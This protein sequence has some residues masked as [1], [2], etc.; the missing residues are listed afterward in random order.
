MKPST[1]VPKA[2]TTQQP[3]TQ[4]PQSFKPIKT[5]MS[6]VKA[7]TIAYKAVT[8]PQNRS[9]SAPYN[10]PTSKPV[11][12][13]QNNESND[14]VQVTR[15]I[16]GKK[17]TMKNTTDKS[18]DRVKITS[19]EKKTNATLGTTRVTLSNN[20]MYTKKSTTPIPYVKSVDKQKTV[21]TT[22]ASVAVPTL[23]VNKIPL[24]VNPSRVLLDQHQTKKNAEEKGN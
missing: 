17:V 19:T 2:P 14:I 3:P 16:P 4:A 1:A 8:K 6:S 7:V 12:A 13:S 10:V 5:T 11:D 20:Q 24:L 15:T 21:V 9:T 18:F 23:K 22:M